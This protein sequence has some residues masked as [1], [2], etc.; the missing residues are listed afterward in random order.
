MTNKPTPEYN[1]SQ[2]EKD[3]N[4]IWIDAYS[5]AISSG[6]MILGREKIE[7]AKMSA[8][9]VVRAM[10]G[11]RVRDI[12]AEYANELEPTAETH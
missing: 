4:A 1:A 10:L 11:H 12:M 9:A 5:D 8:D 2:V 7:S 6:F 3:L